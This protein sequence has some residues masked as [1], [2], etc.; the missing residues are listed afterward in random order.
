M[1]DGFNSL[2]LRE[3]DDSNNYNANEDYSA[4]KRFILT[5]AST[6]IYLLKRLV[7]TL[8]DSDTDYNL[9]GALAALSTGVR[10]V[11]ETT[12]SAELVDLLGGMT[13]K[14][15]ADFLTAGFHLLPV[16]EASTG[17]TRVIQFAREFDGLVVRPGERLAAI[18]ADNLTGLDVNT[19][20]AEVEKQAV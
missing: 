7:V 11:L 20:L 17:A 14:K 12:A 19:V 6:D 2:L 8:Q 9:F 10:L 15:L 16:N 3:S 1:R 13:I 18:Y 4:G 5:P